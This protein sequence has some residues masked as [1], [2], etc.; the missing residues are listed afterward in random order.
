MHLASTSFGCSADAIRL[1]VIKTKYYYKEFENYVET[2]CIV[3]CVNILK[4]ALVVT[5][6]MAGSLKKN[7]KARIVY[8]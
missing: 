8:C 6:L 4:N 2:V 1:L 7:L 5:I 3:W